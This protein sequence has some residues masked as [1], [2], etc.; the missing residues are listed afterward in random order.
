MWRLHRIKESNGWVSKRIFW[1]CISLMATCYGIGISKDG[2]I[3]YDFF[4]I[5]AAFQESEEYKMFHSWG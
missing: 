3:L 1:D 4:E 5:G 2:R